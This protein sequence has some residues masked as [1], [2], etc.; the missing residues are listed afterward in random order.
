M[1]GWAGSV[2]RRASVEP[3]VNAQHEDDTPRFRDD[4]QNT[5]GTGG[6]RSDDRHRGQGLDTLPSAS[7][8][9]PTRSR[10]TAVEMGRPWKSQNDFH[11]R[12]EISHST[13]DSHIPTSRLLFMMY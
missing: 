3:P 12:L 9:Q 2:R 5:D 7:R 1:C 4:R 11:R 6:R 13:R 8:E 10:D